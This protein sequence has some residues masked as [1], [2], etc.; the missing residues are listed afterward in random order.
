MTKDV[1]LMFPGSGSQYVGMARWLY[2]RY[3]QVRTLFDEASQITERDM[4][5][6]CLSGTLVQLAEPTAM[7]L[8]SIP[9]AWPTLSRGSSFGAN[10][11]PCQP[12]YML[13]HSL[14][15]Y[16]ALTC[17]GALSFSSTGAGGD[18]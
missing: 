17:S 5:A 13:G 8:L 7:A 4:A 10:R 1:A 3:P 15:E 18:A 11:C 12:R 16:A 6:L 14:G 9:P 2:E